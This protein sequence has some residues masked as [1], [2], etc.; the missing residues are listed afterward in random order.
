MYKICSKC[1]QTK[2]FHKLGY[3]IPCA[4]AERARVIAAVEAR[5]V[6]REGKRVLKLER[7]RGPEYRAMKREEERESNN[8]ATDIDRAIIEAEFARLT[9]HK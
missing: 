8:L 3:C 5:R 7:I 9:T 6:A 4:D 1:K 2:L